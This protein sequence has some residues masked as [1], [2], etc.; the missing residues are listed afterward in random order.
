MREFHLGETPFFLLGLLK[1][2]F[3][4]LKGIFRNAN[5]GTINK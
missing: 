4:A 3:L 1:N 2:I 5:F